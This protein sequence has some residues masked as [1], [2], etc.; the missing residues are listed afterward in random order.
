M[1]NVVQ[2]F[3]KI[4][5]LVNNAGLSKFGDLFAP[6]SVK[7]F[8]QVLAVNLRGPFL[9]SRY[10]AEKMIAKTDGSPSCIINIASTR[11]LM[12]E[13]N[14]EGYS[15]SKGG[16]KWKAFSMLIQIKKKGL[17][18]LTH[19]LA[20][21]LSKYKSRW[22]DLGKKFF[23]S[24]LVSVRVNCIS[25][26]W[27]DVRKPPENEKELS[28]IAHE[29]HPVGRVGGLKIVMAYFFFK[30][31]LNLVPDD[32]ANMCLFLASPEASF[33]TGQNFVVDGGMTKKMIYQE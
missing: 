22:N 33:I 5:I 15:A 20:M 25:P 2:H 31:K 1:Q 6:D 4:D 11:W 23:Y 3:G 24:H 16:K 21:T 30:N 14:T 17:V 19:S 12:S 10:A 18:A 29:H 32:I 26:G 7:L 27:I 13:P 8:D 9:C 28:Q